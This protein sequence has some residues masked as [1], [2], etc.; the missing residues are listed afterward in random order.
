[1][2]LYDS[3]GKILH[4]P[5]FIRVQIMLPPILISKF[6]TKGSFDFVRLSKSSDLASPPKPVSILLTR[7][8]LACK[9][10]VAS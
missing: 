5:Y 2:N 4:L 7:D 6:L 10:L 1:M 9:W 8:N 3:K